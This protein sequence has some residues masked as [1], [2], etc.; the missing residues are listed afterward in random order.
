MDDEGAVKQRRQKRMPPDMAE[1]PDLSHA[2]EGLDILGVERQRELAV[3]DGILVPHVG[4]EACHRAA[5]A[6]P[7]GHT[8]AHP[9]RHTATPRHQPNYPAK[10]A[11]TCRHCQLL[12]STQS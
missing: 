11:N 3:A 9:H 5:P 2:E 4:L 7:H 10:D 6:H 1:G 12:A 8:A